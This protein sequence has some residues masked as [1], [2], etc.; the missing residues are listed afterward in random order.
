MTQHQYYQI[1]LVYCWLDSEF[2]LLRHNTYIQT[3]LTTTGAAPHFAY[4]FLTVCP[5]D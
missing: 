3:T 5:D 2:T 1:A 4:W